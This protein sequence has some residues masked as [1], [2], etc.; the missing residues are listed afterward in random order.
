MVFITKH[1]SN[2]EM[3]MIPIS[4]EEMNNILKKEEED[5]QEKEKK[6]KKIQQQEK[7]KQQQEKKKQEQE[8]RIKKE[9]E[10][11]QV[12][13]RKRAEEI[14]YIIFGDDFKFIPSSIKRSEFIICNYPSYSSEYDNPEYYDYK[15]FNLSQQ[16]AMP[17]QILNFIQ[18]VERLYYCHWSSPREWGGPRPKE[19][20]EKEK[21][22]NNSNFINQTIMTIE[23]Y[24]KKHNILIDTF[25]ELYSNHKII[26]DPTETLKNKLLHIGNAFYEIEKDI[27]KYK[28]DTLKT[29]YKLK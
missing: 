23:N 4:I 26:F 16:Y 20:F 12:K 3:I 18:E 14:R 10:D 19:E 8:E 22:G 1:L 13:A 29:K 2:G 9:T 24:F 25:L 28:I 5:K 7:R 6:E 11:K 15:I 27:S 21:Y 17:K